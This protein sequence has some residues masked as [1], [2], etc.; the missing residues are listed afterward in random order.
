M[1]ILISAVRKGFCFIT[2]IAAAIVPLTSFASSQEVR[3]WTLGG[4][5]TAAAYAPQRV[6]TFPAAKRTLFIQRRGRL[7][8]RFSREN[9]GLGVQVAEVTG[10]RVKDVLVLD[11]W[12]GSGACGEYTL[13]AGPRLEAVWRRRDCADVGIARLSR[14]ALV[15]WRAVASS[16]TRASGRGI[17]C[18]WSIWRRT[19]WE[20]RADRLVRGRSSLGPSPSAAWRVNLLPGTF[21]H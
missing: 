10:D 20:W 13:L 9:E 16:K 2:A 14:G 21:P 6:P 7:V 5:F 12:D 1:A 18:C 19:R 17:H 3:R 8:R 4:G 11:Y 15:T